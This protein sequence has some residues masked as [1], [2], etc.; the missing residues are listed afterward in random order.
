MELNNQ[1]TVHD[2]IFYNEEIHIKENDAITTKKCFVP[3]WNVSVD[4]CPYFTDNEPVDIANV[5]YPQNMTS[6][7]ISNSDIKYQ[8]HSNIKLNIPNSLEYLDLSNNVL[9]HLKSF[10]MSFPN[11]KSVTWSNNLYSFISNNFAQVAQNIENLIL[12]RNLLGPLL[13]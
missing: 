11:L 2:Q 8:L 12:S 3:T 1:I 7:S 9:Y 13:S 5:T 4:S 6:I 10:F